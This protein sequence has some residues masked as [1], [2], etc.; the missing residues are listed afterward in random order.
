MH[1]SNMT[2]L[3]WFFH[4][5]A[6]EAKQSPTLDCRGLRPRNDCQRKGVFITGPKR[7]F[8]LSLISLFALV[9]SLGAQELELIPAEN[10]SEKALL[11]TMSD[12]PQLLTEVEESNT[13]RA[14]KLDRLEKSLIKINKELDQ[15]PV[16]NEEMADD[17]NIP[18]T[19]ASW[20][21]VPLEIYKSSEAQGKVVE[22]KYN[23]LAGRWDRE[24]GHW[25]RKARGGGAQ[26]QKAFH[27]FMVLFEERLKLAGRMVDAQSG[28]TI[29]MKKQIDALF[30][31]FI[32]KGAKPSDLNQLKVHLTPVPTPRPYKH[33]KPKP[34]RTTRPKPSPTRTPIFKK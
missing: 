4:V 26:F 11:A 22:S 15:T 24:S 31:R 21:S 5:I 2:Y 20:A 30:Q 14:N 9:V 34:N 12:L 33:A 19:L 3:N 17:G 8:I 6:S 25:E 28:R 7:A 16:I 10:P 18:V 27:E 32:Q 1:E 29:E 13:E 23:N